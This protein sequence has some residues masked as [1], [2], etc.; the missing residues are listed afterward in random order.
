MPV[1]AY[2]II[3]LTKPRISNFPFTHREITYEAKEKLSGTT[4][5]VHLKNGRYS[6]KASSYLEIDQTDDISQR[7]LA[8]NGAK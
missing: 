1:A 5:Q 8:P 6:G 4:S 2:V 3:K 7:W